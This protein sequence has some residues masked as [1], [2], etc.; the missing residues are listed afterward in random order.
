MTTPTRLSGWALAAVFGF[1]AFAALVFTAP[2]SLAF[3]PATGASG[4]SFARAEGSL[5]RGR[6]IGARLGPL[7]LGDLKVGANPF[8]LLIGRTR[9]AIHGAGLIGVVTLHGDSV[10]ME[11]IDG[12]L[13]LAA[14]APQAGLSGDL[15]LAKAS[16]RLT[17]GA[18][19]AASGEARLTGLSVQGLPAPGLEPAGALRCGPDGRLVLPLRGQASGVDVEADLGLR[20]DGYALT[21]RIRTTRPDLQAALS[22]AGFERRMEAFVRETSGAFGG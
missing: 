1:S 22:A 16:L 20:P 10:A 11:D 4:L 7:V 5:W 6:L 3:D 14:W 15:S 19:V 8:A 2:L 12:V 13:P 17:D 21:L 9:V 18:C